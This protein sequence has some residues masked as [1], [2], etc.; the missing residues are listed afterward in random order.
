[1]IDGYS[2]LQKELLIPMVLGGLVVLGCFVWKEWKTSKGNSKQFVLNTIVS[3]IAIFSIV[4]TFLEPTK[5][6]EINDRQAL[7]LT[8]GYTENQKD[9][10]INLND[11]IKVLNYNPK[12]SIHKELDSLSNVIIIGDGLEPY[13]FHLFDSVPTTYLPNEQR[14]GITRLSFNEKLLLGNDLSI[15]GSFLKPRKGSFLIVQDSRNNGLDSIQFN[16]ETNIDFELNARP[17][18]SGIYVY[19][20]MVK[21]SVGGVLNTNPLP[22]VI[23][24]KEPLRVLILNEFPTFETKYLKNFL[25]EE[26]H[27]VIVRSQLTKGKFKFEY[28]NTLNVPVYQFTDAV[29]KNFDIVITDAETY[30][31]FGKTMKAAF[32]ESISENGLGLFIQPSDMLFNRRQ[33]DSYFNFK[34]DAIKAQK[35]TAYFSDVEKYPFSFEEQLLVEPIALGGVTNMAGYKQHGKGKIATTTLLNSYEILLN[36]NN[37]IYSSIW[38]TILDKIAKKHNQVF[39]WE[40]TTPLPKIDESFKF[41]VRSN[42][43]VFNVLGEN[44]IPVAIAQKPILPNQYS[45]T[46]YPKRKGWNELHIENDST[47]KFSYYVFDDSDWSALNSVKS[48][49]ANKKRFSK[50][51]QKNRTVI[52]NRPISPILFYILFLLSIGWLWLTPKLTQE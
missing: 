16:E 49:D 43:E 20:L 9:S 8:E 33:S 30:L 18:V 21:D 5:E 22:I 32:E 39:E 7:L 38:T 10:L 14:K 50:G 37:E 47:S 35:L 1:M 45:G 44:N 25:A 19:R 42:I 52:I 46:V 17:K 29:L 41:T 27:E 26:G 40:T 51:F 36:G 24:K 31:S 48:I 13:N 2:F 15:S 28:F 4:I 12:K 3:F 34:R 11:G 23:N 6:V